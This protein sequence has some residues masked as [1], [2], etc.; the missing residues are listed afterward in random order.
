MLVR[1]DF[2][3]GAVV[4]CLILKK[5]G[6]RWHLFIME[7]KEIKRLLNLVVKTEL[8]IT[9]VTDAIISLHNK[10]KLRT[11]DGF[12]EM[13]ESADLKTKQE[14]IDLINTEKNYINGK[15]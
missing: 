5:G 12:L 10:N 11:M 7:E 9:D 8:S 14:F 15:Q 1:W 3:R 13:I 4:C 2:E 6:V